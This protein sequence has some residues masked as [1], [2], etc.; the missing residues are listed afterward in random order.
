MVNDVLYKT[1]SDSVNNVIV[2]F[3]TLLISLFDLVN[4]DGQ[5]TG[6]SER[7]KEGSVLSQ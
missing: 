6:V 4:I 7:I 1:K 3:D 5:H 2:L